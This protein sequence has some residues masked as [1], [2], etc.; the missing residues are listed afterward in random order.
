MYGQKNLFVMPLRSDSGSSNISSG[1]NIVECYK[2][3]F[4][5]GLIIISN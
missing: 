4:M 1:I 2:E 3:S 5:H